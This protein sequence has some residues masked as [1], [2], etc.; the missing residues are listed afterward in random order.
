[1]KFS[2]MKI[3]KVEKYD[4]GYSRMELLKKCSAAT[5]AAL[6]MC[7][8]LASCGND[9]ASNEYAGDL[10]YV[11][12][13]DNEKIAID[14]PDSSCEEENTLDGDIAYVSSDGKN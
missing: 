2:T 3:E 6:L 5:A 13:S 9:V 7:G 1:M 8:G 4:A 14:N 12:Q 10:A 11:S